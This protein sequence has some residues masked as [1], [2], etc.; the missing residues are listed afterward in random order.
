MDE[1]ILRE[2]IA[3]LIH[4][5][6]TLR[7]AEGS[8]AGG[9]YAPADEGLTHLL[10]PIGPDAK[11]E[12]MLDQLRLEIKYLLLDLE[13]TRRENNYLREMLEGKW[14]QGNPPEDL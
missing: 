12:D 14:N 5:F 4:T 13:A 7:P 10:S 6:S 9:L 3:E 11:I 2:R 1:R 8:S